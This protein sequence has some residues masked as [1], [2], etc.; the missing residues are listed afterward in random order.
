MKISNSQFVSRII[1]T[2]SL[3]VLL[4]IGAITFK[5]T[6]NISR[7][8]KVLLETYE[9]NLA[10]E[11]LFNDIVD[12][13]N[14]L[15]GYLITS[16]TTHLR[17]YRNTIK[18]VNYSFL[19]L[20]ALTN[21]NQIQRDNLRMLYHYISERNNKITS[22]MELLPENGVNRNQELRKIFKESD[23]LIQEIREKV[24][25]MIANEE[26]YLKQRNLKYTNQIYLTPILAFGILF[27]ILLLLI[28]TY[29]RTS[30]NLEQLQTTN[31][32][33][34]KSQFLSYQA[35]ILS[36]FGTW[37]WDLITQTLKYSDNFYRILGAEPQSFEATNENFFPFVH[38]EDMGAVNTI[39]EKIL[40]LEEL[41]YSY[42]RIIR[43]DGQIRNLRATGKLFTGEGGMKIV[44]GV[45]EDI[46]TETAKTELLL[47]NN[48]ELQKTNKELKILSE[49][50]K[51]AEI[52]GNYG[53]WI[54]D[55][56]TGRYTYSD[57]KFRLLGFEPQ[58]FYPGI[59]RIL[60]LIHPEDK[61]LIE[62]AYQNSREGKDIPSI[63]YRIIKQDGTIR[64]F[65][66][67]AKSIIDS[68]GKRTLI[69][70][71]QDITEDYNKSLQLKERNKELEQTIKELNEFNYVASHDLQEPLRKIQTFISRIKEKEKDT[72]TE[73]GKDY[74]HRVNVASIRMR[75]LIDDLLQYSKA[76]KEKKILI[77]T[78]LNKALQNSL[79]VLSQKIEEKKVRLTQQRLPAIHGIPFQLQ[80]L[81]TNLLSNSIK[82]SKEDTEPLISITYEKVIAKNEKPL[83][84]NSNRYFHKIN[85]TDNGIGF[86]QVNGEKIFL[87]FKRLHG[88]TEYDGTGVGLAIC[89]KIVE[90]HKGQIFAY[91][92]PEKG[93]TITVYFPV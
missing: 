78:D 1:F 26:S 58:S 8:S 4:F 28:L 18:K 64:L 52:L 19:L 68:R 15:R 70:T 59:E 40:E 81:F 67:I 51:Q 60:E 34:K 74:L 92:K 89:K 41:P 37:E 22:F 57:N 54:L 38:P 48:E 47:S 69:G 79:I 29:Y 87:L 36:E 83:Q 39:I 35:E 76:N 32:K 77:K 42:Y 20:K 55:Y 63:T 25:E 88:K 50:G 21:E 86:E 62:E 44:L 53:S 80:Q 13:E 3:F 16:D 24:S 12:S 14:S 61:Y 93:T 72:L 65:K 9:V 46:T 90:N 84:E 27:I 82:Y 33:L 56:E 7:A 6:T 23:T 5:H 45:T 17:S 43:K 11:H 31:T 71:T 49:S 73:F 85:F 10:L 75:G 2:L 66:T 91:S 30:R